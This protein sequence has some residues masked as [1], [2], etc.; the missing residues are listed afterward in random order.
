MLTESIDQYVAPLT[1]GIDAGGTRVRAR[2]VDAAGRVV[3]VGH[4]GPGNALSVERA[5]LVRTLE[6]T[7][8]AAVPAALRG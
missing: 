5:V 2:C 4:G 7:V 3:G 1:V 6:Q 8:A